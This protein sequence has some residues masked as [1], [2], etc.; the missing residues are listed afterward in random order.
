MSN[1]ITELTRQINNIADVR[2]EIYFLNDVEINTV[3][4]FKKYN[5][6][7]IN[8]TTLNDDKRYIITYQFK[9]STYDVLYYK[10]N[11]YLNSRC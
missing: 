6:I 2:N 5:Q 3:S 10:F 11:K 8:I 4:G 7:K 1:N 9:D